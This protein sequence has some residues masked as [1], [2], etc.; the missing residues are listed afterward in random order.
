MSERGPTPRGTTPLWGDNAEPLTDIQ[1]AWKNPGH[2][3]IKR[4]HRT[5]GHV[6]IDAPKGA[7]GYS[8]AV[9][10]LGCG[11]VIAGAPVIGATDGIGPQP[12]GRLDMVFV[13]GDTPGEYRTTISVN[14]GNAVQFFVTAEQFF[15][16][17]HVCDG[18]S[19]SVAS[20]FMHAAA[21]VR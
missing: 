16:E 7:S 8:I 12:A 3:L 17:V 21:P 4:G 19:C 6:Y 14:N 18:A 13:A 5:I 20:F 11:T 15:S 9:N 10:P 2:A 1:L